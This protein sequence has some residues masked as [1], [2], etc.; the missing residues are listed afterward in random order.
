MPDSHVRIW[1]QARQSAVLAEMRHEPL[2]GDG[3][4]PSVELQKAVASVVGERVAEDL[5]HML[6][7]R[8]RLA[9]KQICELGIA[10]ATALYRLQEPYRAQFAA[11]LARSFALLE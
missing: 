7:A 3:R 4:P 8:G 11:S 10:G 1:M 5:D 9:D 6:T 2:A